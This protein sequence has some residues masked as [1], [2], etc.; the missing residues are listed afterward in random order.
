M[1]IK[2]H[3]NLIKNNY[4]TKKFPISLVHFVTNRCNARC[5]FCFID[6]DNPDTF[7]GE[8]TVDEIRKLSLTL[9]NSLQNIN[10][11][12]GEP[13][14]RKELEDIS[15]IYITNSKVQSL[16]ITSN[17]SL[18][19]RIE[20]YLTK[21]SNKFPNNKFVFSYSIDNI[22]EKHDKI[23]KI[24]GLFE[25]CIQ[26]YKLLDKF[27]NNV[28]GNISITV[29]LENYSEIMNIYNQLVDKYNVKAIK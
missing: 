7:K 18:P 12:G 4:I 17:G 9:G 22:E 6:F 1:T 16:F 19:D 14:A 23:R 2:T 8:L 26:S 15:E 13:F 21:L 3:Y 10:I 27:G 24:K 20:T 25:N 5:S 29:S 11:T 28:F